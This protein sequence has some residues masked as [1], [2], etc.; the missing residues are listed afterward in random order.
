[1]F[2]SGKETFIS[3]PRRT[4]NRRGNSWSESISARP[5]DATHSYGQI[6]EF[7]LQAASP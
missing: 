6:K 7:L 4:R 3:I 1:L 2:V 5:Q